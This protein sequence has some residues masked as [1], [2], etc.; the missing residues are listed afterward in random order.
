MSNHEIQVG[1]AWLAV[2]LNLTAESGDPSNGVSLATAKLF[3]FVG[4][5]EY[6]TH[7]VRTIGI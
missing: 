1:T 5:D 4:N 6:A 3:D 7:L 2:D